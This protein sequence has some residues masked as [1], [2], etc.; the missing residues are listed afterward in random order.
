MP[1]VELVFTLVSLTILL[2]CQIYW[3]RG[4]MQQYW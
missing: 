4:T 3:Q 2:I 1:D